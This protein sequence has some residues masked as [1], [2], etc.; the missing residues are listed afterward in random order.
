[1]RIATVPDETKSDSSDLSALAQSI[2]RR[3]WVVAICFF[4]AIAASIALTLR[5]EKQYAATS[6]LLLRPSSA[7]EP[8][9]TVETN[10][11]LLS[12]PVLADRTSQK[13]HHQLT[14]EEVEES[15]ELSQE[16]ESDIVRVKAT[17]NDPELA[18]RMANLYADAFISF[19]QHSGSGGEEDAEGPDQVRI[20]DRATREDS[21]VSPKPAKNLIFGALVGLV[22]GLG[23]ALLLEQLDTRVKRESDLGE[24]TDLPV[25]ATIPRRKSLSAGALAEGAL[26]P[27]EVEIFLR[28]RTSLRYFNSR[29]DLRSLLVTSAG[30]GEGKTVVSV[31]IALAAAIAGER[32]LLIEGDLRD[33]SLSSALRIPRG[34]GLS[35]VLADE[36]RDIGEV[37]VPFRG[38]QLA[39]SAG[40]ARFDVLASGPIP[41]NPTEL[42]ASQRMRELIAE[43]E[44]IYDFVIVD[45]PPILLVADTIPLVSLVAGVLAVSGVGV[46]DRAAVTELTENLKMM[47]AP[48]LGMVVNFAPSRG[49]TLDGYGYGRPPELGIDG[50]GGMSIGKSSSRHPE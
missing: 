44:K 45:S 15:V 7:V 14:G 30:V 43:A 25:L 46:S 34:L 36:N 27:A 39:R 8:Q 33:P 3:I 28:L 13:L 49:R 41:P 24:V 4:V 9:R 10:L 17:A 47:D 35:G 16:G 19:K 1:V 20:V 40:N 32:V 22:L 18:A 6:S 37:I 42:V 50:S 29:Q 5:A 38:T 12:L 31:G 48:T 11:Q 2:R 26:T 23:L 21:A